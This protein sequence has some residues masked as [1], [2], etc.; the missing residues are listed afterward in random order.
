MVSIPATLIL[1]ALSSMADSLVP[2]KELATKTFFILLPPLTR[3]EDFWQNAQT[4]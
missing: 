4:G 1:N 2:L 3:F